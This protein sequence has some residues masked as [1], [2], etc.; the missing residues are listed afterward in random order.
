MSTLVEPSPPTGAEKPTVATGGRPPRRALAAVAAL[1]VAAAGVGF[2]V[3]AFG[4]GERT[5][6][7]ATAHGK[8]AFATGVGGHWQI[9]TVNADGTAMTPLTDLSTDQ[10]HPAWS[11]DGTKVA[12]DAQDGRGVSQIDVVDA[13]GSNLQT[14]TQGPGWNYLPAWSPDGARIA[15]VSNR[16]GN[17]EIYVMNADGSDQE[18][19]TTDPNEDLSPNW[20]PDATRIAFQ[21]N[22][23]GFNRIYVMNPDGSGVVGLTES[24]GFD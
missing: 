2:A 3:V 13:H 1:F 8:I 10:F 23:D 17:D 22:R 21:S 20:S 6:P 11:P 18:R 19:L 5:N 24:E 12:F 7:A 16:D 15:F 4:T 14:L 9:V